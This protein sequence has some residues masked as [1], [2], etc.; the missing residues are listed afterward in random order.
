MT[1]EKYYKTNVGQIGV[2]PLESNKNS[3]LGN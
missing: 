2:I 1:M 3:L